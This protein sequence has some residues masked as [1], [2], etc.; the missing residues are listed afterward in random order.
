MFDGNIALSKSV[1][2][3]P[4]RIFYSILRSG[5]W[6]RAVDLR[7]PIQAAVRVGFLVYQLKFNL[8]TVRSQG[9]RSRIA[10]L[11]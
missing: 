11:P 4:K 2:L 1:R 3:P 9:R 7:G 10:S 8:C 6:R 5:P